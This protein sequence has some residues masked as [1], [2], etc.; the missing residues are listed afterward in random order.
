MVIKE[1]KSEEL[2]LPSLTSFLS[3]STYTNDKFEQS[4]VVYVDIVS[5]PADSKDTVLQVLCKLHAKFIVELGFLW[6]IVVGDAK[7]YDILQNLRRQYGSQMQWL[8]PFPGDWHI[9]YNY[10]KVLLKIYGEAGLLQLAKV[11]GHRAETLRSLAQASHFK[12]THHFI[13]QSFEAMYRSF[14]RTYL[15]TIES[16]ASQAVTSTA[17]TLANALASITSDV[18]LEVLLEQLKATFS[19]T[20]QDFTVGFRSFMNDLCKSQKTCQFWHDY[21]TM[22]SLIYMAL[23]IAIRNADWMLRMA[24]IKSMAAVFCAFDRP[25]YQNLIPRHLA[26]LLCFPMPVIQHLKKGAFTVHL[27]EGSG[28]AVGLDEA[29]EMKINKDAKFAA[30]RP[31]PEMME[32]I[33]NFMPFRT[34]C[35]NNLK[36][37][38]GMEKQPVKSLPMATS[39][40]RTANAN[41]QVMID[42]MEESHMFPKPQSDIQLKNPF[43]DI[44]ATPEQTH[45]L[46]NFQL[47]GQIEF[48]DHVNCRILHTPSADAP[49]RRKRLQTFGSTKKTQRKLKRIERDRK[50]QQT[51]MKKQLV[52]LARGEQLPTECGSYFIQ[53]PCALSDPD[54]LPHKGK[55]VKQ[56]ISLK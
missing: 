13:I 36:H 45:D 10:Q 48:E 27:T 43:T 44:P 7:T 4:K 49:R 21:L 50:I 54:G 18:G 14:I 15:A 23:F 51:C 3:A 55:R 33:S 24:A 47:I 1:G 31:S 46:L 34:K 30:V 53:H 19:T 26:D 56:L 11:A 6:L 32:K 2:D 35:L 25:I 40:D 38:L 29:H 12:R 20:L 37:H 52:V 16:C 28:H 8:L 5:L 41:I 39:Q 22:N 42:L 17:N 9:L